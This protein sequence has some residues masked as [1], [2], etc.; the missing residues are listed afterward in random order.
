MTEEQKC[1]AA[2]I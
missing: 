1:Q 2:K